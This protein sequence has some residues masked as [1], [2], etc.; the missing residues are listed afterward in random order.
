MQTRW[1]FLSTILFSLYFC[2][3]VKMKKRGTKLWQ[4]SWCEL[5][6]SACYTPCQNSDGP[7]VDSTVRWMVRIS[8]VSKRMR[9][10]ILFFSANSG[11]KLECWMSSW[12][13]KIYMVWEVYNILLGKR[14]VMVDRDQREWILIQS[15]FAN[16]TALVSWSPKQLQYLVSRLGKVREESKLRV[17]VEKS[18]VTVVKR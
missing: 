16:D 6:F 10:W 2:A 3:T 8:A 11:L 15:F 17:K 1:S 5:A 18:K 4:E 9:M 13:F 12:L 14:V 7:C